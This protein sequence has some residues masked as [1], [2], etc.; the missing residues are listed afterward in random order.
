MDPVQRSLQLK[1]QRDQRELASTTKVRRAFF[2]KAV[3][4][5]DEEEAALFAKRRRYDPGTEAGADDPRAGP[6]AATAAAAAPAP[7]EKAGKGAATKG[8]ANASTSFAAAATASADLSTFR[9]EGTTGERARGDGSRGAQ[10]SAAAPSQRPP[11]GAPLAAGGGGRQDGK[12]THHRP[13]PKMLVAPNR[14]SGALLQRT[15]LLEERAQSQQAG[16]DRRDV[17]AQHKRKRKSLAQQYHAR[18][19]RGQPIMSHRSRDLLARVER[20]V[21]GK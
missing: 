1:R 11:R 20:A 14:F 10:P 9:S 6:S 5:V 13:L 21:G 19:S 3:K 7:R 16:A 18:T 15:K 2:K 8:A 17:V 12:P 4:Q